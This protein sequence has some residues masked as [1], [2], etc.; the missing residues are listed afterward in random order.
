MA[1]LKLIVGVLLSAVLVCS[2]AYF[3]KE[4]Y[5]KVVLGYEDKIRQIELDAKTAQV[6]E[7]SR[8][9]NKNLE[10]A[11]KNNQLDREWS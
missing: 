11:A 7:L 3:T 6:E 5:E 1:H 9:L 10:L 4:H 2:G 8:V